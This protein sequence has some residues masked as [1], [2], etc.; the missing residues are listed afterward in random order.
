VQEHE[1]M[2][3]RQKPEFGQFLPL[4]DDARHVQVL[5]A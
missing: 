3:R 4:P 5:D 2:S 1:A